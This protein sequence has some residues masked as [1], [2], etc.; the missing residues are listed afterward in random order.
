MS[1]LLEEDR[2]YLLNVYR[3][4][5]LE[6]IRG[7]GSYLMDV[8]GNRYLDLFSGIAVNSLGHAHP[9]VLEVIQK[10][11]S[12]YLHLSNYFASKPVINL[13]KLLVENSFAS[14]VFFSNSGTE[15][16]E[17]A[18]KLVRK[19]GRM[20]HEKK[21]E[22]LSFYQSFHGRTLGGLTLTGQDKYKEMFQ[23][24]LPGVT[25]V[26]FNDVEDLRNKV[27]DQTCA[28][29]LE[30]IQGEG[31]VKEI[32]QRFID[33]LVKLSKEFDFLIVVDDIQAGLC[34]TGPLFSY[35]NYDFKP[36]L[37][38]LAKSLGGGIP[39]GALLISKRLEDVLKPGDHGSTF[40]GNPLAC[41]VGEVVLDT[42]SQK[43]FQQEVINKGNVLVSKLNELR[44][45]YPMII[46]QVRGKGLMI[47]IET[48]YAEEIKKKA[49][50]MKV[51]LNVTSGTVVR[52]LPPLNITINELNHFLDCFEI[53][54][55][56]LS[57]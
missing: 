33:E 43:D 37:L 42:F 2:E 9:K 4:M 21:I 14:K 13:A 31:G 7:E 48:D 22:I 15:A 36:D 47:G 26:V 10:Q 51:L 55:E 28:F 49:L 41:A 45:L 44:I 11:A 18:I 39:L 52:L 24:I 29:F 30:T 25:H 38:T 34:R 46:K 1:H 19:Y 20:K 54:L 40:G 56:E 3:R 27:S 17:A 57:R 35:E 32:N 6:M 23:P 12:H 5:N 53:I 16:N 50:E 8:N